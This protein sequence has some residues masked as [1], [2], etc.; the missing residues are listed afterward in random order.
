MTATRDRGL[1]NMSADAKGSWRTP[2]S[3]ICPCTAFR[4]TGVRWEP[5]PEDVD[6]DVAA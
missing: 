6:A 5:P 3:S 4:A 2:Q 1:Q